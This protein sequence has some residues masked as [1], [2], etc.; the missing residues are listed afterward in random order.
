ML[1]ADIPKVST[2]TW[3]STQP[4]SVPPFQTARL[5]SASGCG[6]KTPA[7]PRSFVFILSKRRSYIKAVVPLA[8][9]N[10]EHHS[11]R[12][13]SRSSSTDYLQSIF[14]L[15]ISSATSISKMTVPTTCCG[16]SDGNCVCAAQAK[17]SCGKQS[18]LNCNCEKAPTENTVAG[19]RCSCR[20]CLPAPLSLPPPST[21]AAL[22]R[23][24][25]P[26]GK[27]EQLTYLLFQVP[28]QLE[29]ATAIVPLQRTARWRA[30]LVHVDRGL[31]VS[32]PT[33]GCA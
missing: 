8:V 28:A 27:E 25:E 10:F 1:K 26:T 23:C 13:Q 11:Q 15:P 19:A 32:Y 9:S 17:C 24:L 20:K 30:R 4:I 12:Q 33:L 7:V 3:R 16:R 2:L 21:A 22:P 6:I 29:I 5:C 18:A 31:L 14:P